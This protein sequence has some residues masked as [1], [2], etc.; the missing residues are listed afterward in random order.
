[1]SDAPQFI[2]MATI[3]HKSGKPHLIEIWYVE[4]EG[5]YYLMSEMRE[6]AAWVQNVMHN[7]NIA[8]YLAGGQN[9][10]FRGTARIVDA[11]AEPEKHA[12]VVALMVAKYE[13]G[14][15]VMVELI[16]DE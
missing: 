16:P 3:G 11:T 5:R 15:G 14:D 9:T 7:P 6:K 12:A 8:A 1:M 10:H 13:W 4:R 2:Y